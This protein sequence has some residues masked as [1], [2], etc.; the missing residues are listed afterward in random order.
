MAV[1]NGSDGLTNVA[2]AGFGATQIGALHFG[3]KLA[4]RLVS[5][6]ISGFVD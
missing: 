2:R 3:Q 6:T 5:V 1:N 4:K